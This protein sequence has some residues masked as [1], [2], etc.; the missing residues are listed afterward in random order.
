MEI[1][2]KNFDAELRRGKVPGYLEQPHA[3]LY[4][5]RQCVHQFQLRKT[6]GAPGVE[7][8]HSCKPEEQQNYS[9][10]ALCPTHANHFTCTLGTKYEPSVVGSETVSLLYVINVS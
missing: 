1:S 3:M 9:T 6:A 4:F 7:R 8:G 2:S 5:L 10:A